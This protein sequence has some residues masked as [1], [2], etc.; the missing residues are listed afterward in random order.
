M[1]FEA[2]SE[3]AERG[4][5]ILLT[6]GLLRYHL[7]KDGTVTIREILVLPKE[8]GKG[9]GLRMLVELTRRVGAH[10]VV[11]AKCPA[12][13]KANEW[14][15]RRGFK[16]ISS[17]ELPSGRKVNLWERPPLSTVPTATRSLPLPLSN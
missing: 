7:R 14:Y 13:L 11:R 12:D 4:E 3:S 6:G 10:R 2:L 5:L 15:A 16:L 8:R 9:C 17:E 1:L